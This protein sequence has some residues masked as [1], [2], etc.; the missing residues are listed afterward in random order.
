MPE[1]IDRQSIID[2]EHLK[3]LSFWDAYLWSSNSQRTR[4]REDIGHNTDS[5]SC[6]LGTTCPERRPRG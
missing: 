2:E 3:L 1:E 6:A 5:E 4:G